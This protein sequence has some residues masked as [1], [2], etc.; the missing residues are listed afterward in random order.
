MKE[1][2]FL[3]TLAIT[4]TAAFIA[5]RMFPGETI[6]AFCSGFLATLIIGLMLVIVYHKIKNGG[7]PPWSR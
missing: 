2:T 7:W 4:M 3:E 1:V 5:M 6:I